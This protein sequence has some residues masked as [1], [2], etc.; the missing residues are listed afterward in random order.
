MWHVA[1][2]GSGVWQVAC[3]VVARGIVA[4][5]HCGRCIV[6]LGWRK[7]G[8]CI[9]V[10]TWHRG[11]VALWR[12]A[13]PGWHGGTAALWRVARGVPDGLAW[14]QCGTVA[15]WHGGHV[16]GWLSRRRGMVL[17]T[18]VRARALFIW[19]ARPYNVLQLSILTTP[20]PPLLL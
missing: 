12:V 9:D 14:R 5:W 2:A 19:A 18:R 6:I 1:C 10:A 4:V 16:A 3:G 20:E 7:I 17:A 11:I 13:W 8:D 15:A